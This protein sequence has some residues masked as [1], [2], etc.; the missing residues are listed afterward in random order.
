MALISVSHFLSTVS[1]SLLVS[2]S[3]CNSHTPTSDL[4][5]F[6]P[7]PTQLVQASAGLAHL[8][9]EGYDPSN[10]TIVGDSVGGT[11][12]VFLLAHLIHKHPAADA[13]QLNKPLAG[14]AALSPWLCY[15]IES[16]S[17]KKWGH[18]DDLP[19]AVLLRWSGLYKA[20]R[21]RTDDDYYFEPALAPYTWWAGLEK[22]AQNVILAG[23]SAEGMF[24]DVVK[25]ERAME[26]GAGKEVKL[27]CFAHEGGKHNE[28]VIEMAARDGA[29]ATN[30][31]ML[32]WIKEI[33]A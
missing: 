27:E 20:T 23:G 13:V 12:I 32:Q 4:S 3:L 14:A 22:V 31:R 5:N 9:K 18:T 10:I 17:W 29:G 25:T 1:S 11:V 15:G 26:K 16:N 19:L 7:W 6:A 24:D 21:T 2:A 33:Y 28:A 8:L 30:F